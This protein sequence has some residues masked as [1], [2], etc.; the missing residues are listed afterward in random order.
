MFDLIERNKYLIIHFH[1]FI[2]VVVGRP[3]SILY[4]GEGWVINR[5]ALSV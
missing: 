4:A 5:C 3:G 2:V 1:H